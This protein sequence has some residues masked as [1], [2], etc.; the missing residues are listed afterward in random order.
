M[1]MLMLMTYGQ[2][3]SPLKAANQRP[4]KQT[5]EI[6]KCADSVNPQPERRGGSQRL[7]RLT[8]EMTTTQLISRSL[9]N[10]QTTFHVP[11]HNA[12]TLVRRCCAIFGQQQRHVLRSGPGPGRFCCCG[13][14]CSSC[15]RCCLFSP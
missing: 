15:S 11:L 12:C 5:A 7:Q 8:C 14:C 1:L 10:H 13:C 4:P 6:F 2:W 3:M 9:H